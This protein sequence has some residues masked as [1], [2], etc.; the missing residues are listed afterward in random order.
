MGTISI[1]HARVSARA[2]GATPTDAAAAAA[3]AAEPSRDTRKAEPVS[4]ELD[5][6]THAVASTAQLLNAINSWQ[7]GGGSL[8][9]R[10]SPTIISL[11]NLAALLV[12]LCYRQ[13]HTRHR[14]V[15]LSCMEN[16][17]GR[18]S[19]GCSGIKASYTTPLLL[20]APSDAADADPPAC[21]HVQDGH[22]HGHAAWRAPAAFHSQPQRGNGPGPAQG[23]PAWCLG[24]SARPAA[25]A[26]R[27]GPSWRACHCCCT[28][29]CIRTSVYASLTV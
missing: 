21:P 8:V 25:H 11:F 26:D 29:L 28:C 22:A 23:G 14:C 3:A 15:L 2:P 17:K 19:A 27:C 6:T 18:R 16:W 5:V 7:H 10:A 1:G 24:C 12:A 20:C 13:F 9:M 4:W